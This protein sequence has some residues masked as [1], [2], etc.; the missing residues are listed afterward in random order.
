MY[1][2]PWGIWRLSFHVKPLW[3][4]TH[5]VFKSLKSVDGIIDLTQVAFSSLGRSTL[6]PN[7]FVWTAKEEVS[8]SVLFC[9]DH[10]SCCLPDAVSGEWY[11]GKTRETSYLKPSSRIMT[12]NLVHFGVRRSCVWLNIPK[13]CIFT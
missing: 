12:K 5:W 6:L 4:T 9:S 1:G 2:K 10:S 3:T 11:V 7:S 13:N 8:L